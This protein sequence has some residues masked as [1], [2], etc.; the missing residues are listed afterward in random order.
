MHLPPSF[1]VLCRHAIVGL[2][3]RM[4]VIVLT[5]KQTK[6]TPLKTSNILRYTMTLGNNVISHVTTALPTVLYNGLVV[7]ACRRL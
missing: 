5:N 7:V 2:T 4:E 6:Q 3:A 1:I